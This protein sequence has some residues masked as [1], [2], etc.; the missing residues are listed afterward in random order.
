MEKFTR[1]YL[2]VG[3]N[4]GD[5]R[6]FLAKAQSL[7]RKIP[8]TRFL[9]ESSIF[10]TDPVGGPPQGKFL[11]AVWEIETSLSPDGLKDELLQIE[12]KLGRRRTVRNAPREI[13]LDILFFGDRIVEEKELQIPHPRLHE[14]AFVLFPLSELAPEKVHPKLKKTVREIM[15]GLNCLH[16]NHS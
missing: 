4:L 16:E 6:I 2:G 1:V 15:E 8:A 13:D 9:R 7:I 12:S 3:S 10:E 11:N 14:R 5:R